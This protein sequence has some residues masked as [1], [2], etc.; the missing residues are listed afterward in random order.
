[1][2]SALWSRSII[3]RL[4]L[5]KTLVTAS[6][7]AQASAQ[8]PTICLVYQ[9]FEEQKWN[10]LLLLNTLYFQVNRYRYWIKFF[11][12]KLNS[13]KL[14]FV[15]F[16]AQ[17]KWLNLLCCSRLFFAGSRNGDTRLN[18]HFKLVFAMQTLFLAA[19]GLYAFK[20]ILNYT[21]TGIDRQYLRKDKWKK[22]PVVSGVPEPGTWYLVPGTW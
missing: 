14:T 11:I 22:V 3:P 6:S 7:L 5:D 16:S 8:C 21:G 4:Q 19:N 9:K 12:L 1:M 20:K 2:T 18:H 10:C 17:N 13:R 15:A